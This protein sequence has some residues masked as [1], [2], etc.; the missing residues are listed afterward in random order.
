M[1]WIYPLKSHSAADIVAATKEFLADV[2]G[3]IKCFRTDYA[4]QFVNEMFM[5]VC[6]DKTM[7]H[8]HTGVDEP[9]HNGVVE[10]GLGLTQEGGIAACLEAPDCSPGCSRTWTAAGWKWQYT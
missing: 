10:R 6:G 1:G 3:D 9:K 7:R 2:A 4:V 5:K 8:E